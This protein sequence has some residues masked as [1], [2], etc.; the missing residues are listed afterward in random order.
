MGAYSRKD[1]H[2]LTNIILYAYSEICG[3]V[4]TDGLLMG[5]YAGG[6][7]VLSLVGDLGGTGVKGLVMNPLCHTFC[8]KLCHELL[9]EVHSRLPDHHLK[10]GSHILHCYD[11][12]R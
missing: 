7:A 8:Y 1:I 4:S 3:S 6:V 2:V 5:L 10:K 12:L 11:I 9:Q